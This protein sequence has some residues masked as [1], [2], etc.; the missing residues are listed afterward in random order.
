M[1]AARTLPPCLPRASDPR[2]SKMHFSHLLT[3]SALAGAAVASPLGLPHSIHEKR[4][5][6]PQG[7]AK[8]NALDRRAI[9]PMKIGMAQSNMDRGWEWLSEVSVP[10]S[11]KYGK[12]WTA[13]EIAEAFAPSDKTVD[14]VKT[15]LTSA[16]IPDS[17]I[18]QSQGLNW[19]EFD[20]TVDE[21][22]ELL[23]TKYNVYEHEET[24]QPHVACEEYSIPS[25]LK[26]HI[27]MVYPTVWSWKGAPCCG[28]ANWTT[29]SLRPEGQAS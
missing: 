11:P 14:A 27:D 3:A 21:A 17:R 29:D 20:A 12:H 2:F 7:W 6:A 10:T 24:G 18:K 22:E 19:L 15:W 8:R 13:K 23:K 5:D 16:G 25:H 28:Q 9:L 4:N 1:N 26:E